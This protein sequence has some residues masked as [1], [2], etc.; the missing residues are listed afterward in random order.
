[1]NSGDRMKKV[2]ITIISAVLVGGIFALFYFKGTKDSIVD[3]L[4]IENEASAFQV[5]VYQKYDN[6]KKEAEKYPSGTI[7]QDGEFYRVYIAIANK[8]VSSILEDYYDSQGIIYYV[9]QISIPDS[10][11]NDFSHYQEILAN[12]KEYDSI[13]Q[14]I[15]KE[16]NE[17]RYE[18]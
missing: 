8:E 18:I 14:K 15:L 10:F 9:R 2:V 6:A 7:I 4:Y 1:M 12:S 17:S 5:G 3:A 11:L 16:Y 13:N